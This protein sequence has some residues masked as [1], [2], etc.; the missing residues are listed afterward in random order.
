MT[1][2]DALI[3]ETSFA[4]QS[5]W[6]QHHL[7]PGLSAYNITAAVRLRGP[8]DTAALE[9]A[10][11]T[12]AGRHE[13]LRTVFA[14]EGGEPV[15]VIGPTAPLAVPVEAATPQEVAAAAGTE[16]SR[17][18]DL[19][20]GPLLRMRLLRLGEEH[21]VALL[22]MHHIVTDG[23]SSD[24]FLRELATVYA[25]RV[26]GHEPLLEELPLQYA[27]FAVWQRKT[28]VG[29][30]LE[31]LVGHWSQALTGAAPLALPT[32]LP[33]PATAGTHAVT[34]RFELPAAL[35]ERL[36]RRAHEGRA[37]L[38][39]VLLAALDALLARYCR[40]QDITVVAPMVGRAR[41]ELEG[42]IGYFVNPLLLRTDVSGDPSFTELLGRARTTCLDAFDHEDLP[43]EQ[44]V[45]A[46]RRHGAPQAEMLRSQ[47]LLVLQNAR[48]DRWHSA[49]IDFELIPADVDSAKA[50]LLLEVRPEPDGG[51]RAGLEYRTDLFTAAT[52]E[53][54]AT[55]L[56]AVLD[57][58]TRRP[59]EP[60]SRLL[61]AAVPAA[62]I[63]LPPAAPAGSGAP[64][65]AGGDGSAPRARVA[66]R[67][68]LE[69]E[70]AAIW[71]ELLA[72]DDVGV[73]DNFYDLGGQSLLAVR[74]VAQL[75]DRFGVEISPRELYSDFT[76]AT[77]AW[78]VLCRMAEED[79]PA[80]TDAPVRA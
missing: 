48:P 38:F 13:V 17:P 36:R 75:R 55:H 63:P 2:D 52:I 14:L 27:D 72:W 39:M 56:L 51:C 33:P 50:D 76:V 70:I 26:A 73:Y 12:V 9:Y 18:F 37:T 40:Q 31:R 34:H 62:E 79:D 53:R 43:F 78:R 58:A 77:V 32:D 19:G 22:A 20:T 35:T 49:G 66:P 23:A 5:L 61:D 60:L 25:A 7:D 45:K 6:L 65:Q 4:Q 24:I 21:H 42:L 8:L 15:Q 11:N 54:F 28:L 47:V 46:L 67:T 80:G 10:L 44:A 16:L 30:E 68:P 57:A 71:R 69:E 3:V 64:G 1:A 74:L 59:D 29:A 41:P